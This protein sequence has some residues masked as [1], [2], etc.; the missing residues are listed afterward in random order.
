MEVSSSTV[1]QR[2]LNQTSCS[3]DSLSTGF[4]LRWGLSILSSLYLCIRS[5]TVSANELVSSCLEVWT[6]R[7][8]QNS[9]RVRCS[10]WQEGNLADIWRMSYGVKTVFYH[11]W[12]R[13]SLTK[14]WLSYGYS[15]CSSVAEVSVYLF[16]LVSVLNSGKS[17]Y[18]FCL[19]L[20]DQPS[21]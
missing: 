10:L 20:C 11:R 3:W 14:N 7:S 5:F 21:I 17:S 8:L 9:S 4:R 18:F 19:L 12:G 13:F 15:V 2:S 16:F 6:R 1:F